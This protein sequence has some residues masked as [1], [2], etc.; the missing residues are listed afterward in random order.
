MKQ[1]FYINSL[2]CKLY[3]KPSYDLRPNIV[4][5]KKISKISQSVVPSLLSKNQILQIAVKSFSV[6]L[7][8]V[9]G[10]YFVPNVLTLI[11]CPLG[12]Q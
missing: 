9:R 8:F 12:I 1:N 6:E 7:N 4:V 11:L 5:I 2:L 3:L 10:L